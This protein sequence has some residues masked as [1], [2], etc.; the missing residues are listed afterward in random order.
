[1]YKSI[2]AVTLL[3]AGIANASPIFEFYHGNQSQVIANCKYENGHLYKDRSGL[4]VVGCVVKTPTESLPP[5]FS[6]ATCK[7]YR[8]DDFGDKDTVIKA[9]KLRCRNMH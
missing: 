5:Y 2:V 3:F 9:L 6:E 7:L 1:M 4:L 8:V